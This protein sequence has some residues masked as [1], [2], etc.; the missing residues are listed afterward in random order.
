MEKI[1]INTHEKISIIDVQDINYLEAKGAYTVFVLINGVILKASK[2]LSHFT[3][4]I[5]CPNLLRLERG[6]II[7][8]HNLKEIIKERLHCKIVFKD[9]TELKLSKNISQRLFNIL[10]EHFE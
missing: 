2:N 10:E 6:T 1:L 8:I 4:H 5:T 9:K 3:S 7:N